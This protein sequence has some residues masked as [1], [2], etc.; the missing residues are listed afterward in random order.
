MPT[1]HPTT[2]T[3]T[4]GPAPGHRA[5]VFGALTGPPTGSWKMLALSGAISLIAGFVALVYPGISLLALSTIVGVGLLFWGG[6]AI[7]RSVVDPGAHAS[8]RLMNVLLGGLGIFAGAVSLVRPGA[9]IL[10]LVLTLG[11][12][13]VWTG[14]AEFAMG[15]MVGWHRG[16]HLA[17]GALSIVAGIVIL[18]DPGVGVA[19]LAL[20][21]GIAFVLR[22]V[23]ELTLAQAVRKTA[24]QR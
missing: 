6:A 4:T 21:V 5:P 9:T 14:A 2:D 11:F 17:L 12:W 10:A 7:G 20:I 24:P 15:V 23:G 16:V 8:A 3:P 1:T 22:G 18:A 19:T 13:W